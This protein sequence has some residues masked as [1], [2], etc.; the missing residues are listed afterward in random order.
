MFHQIKKEKMTNFD[1]WK[2]FKI[3]LIVLFLAFY[4]MYA[5]FA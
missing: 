2:N 4:V 3:T 5:Q 1:K